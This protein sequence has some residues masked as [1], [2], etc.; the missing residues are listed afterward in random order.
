MLIVKIEL[1]SARTGKV[2]EIGRMHIS[3][4]GTGTPKR[5]NYRVEVMRKGSKTR[6]QREGEVNNYPRQSYSVWELVKRSIE[7]TLYS[8]KPNLIDRFEN[9]AQCDD[10][11]DP[12]EDAEEAQPE[13]LYTPYPETDCKGNFGDD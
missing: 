4:R 12:P 9:D 2:T 13:Q 10:L 3:N 6:V 8:G 5:G 1:H 7:H 11:V